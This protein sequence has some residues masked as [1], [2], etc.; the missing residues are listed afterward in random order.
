MLP[1]RPTLAPAAARQR[2]K[3]GSS[4]QVA[5]GLGGV[6]LLVLL[7]R[8]AAGPPGLLAVRGVP[9]ASSA[10][11]AGARGT[12]LRPSQLQQ[13]E[14]QL[15]ERMLEEEASMQARQRRQRGTAGAALPAPAAETLPPSGVTVGSST[16]QPQQQQQ[17]RQLPVGAA[18]APR[19]LETAQGSPGPGPAAAVAAAGLAV[20]PAPGS[21][22]A[23]DG[24]DNTT[25]A[26]PRVIHQCYLAGKADKLCRRRLL[27]CMRDGQVRL[28]V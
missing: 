26:I 20:S 25:M 15:R 22:P 11:P 5:L 12:L 3:G 23:E 6:V 16:L 2:S 1:P 10:A 28:H 14:Q 21:G 27:A 13:H 24:G 8:H 18:A 17:P 4:R 19:G 9:A 7:W